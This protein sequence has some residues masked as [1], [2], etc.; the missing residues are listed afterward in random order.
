MKA[1]LEKR[2]IFWLYF[3]IYFL[4]SGLFI[5]AFLSQTKVHAQNETV[6]A[7]LPEITNL[8]FNGDRSAQVQVVISNV[9]LLNAFDITLI[10]DSTVTAVTSWSH[11]GFLS[12]L[13]CPREINDPGFFRLACTQLGIPGVSGSGSLINLT[14]TGTTTGST[15][16]TIDEGS[17]KLPDSNNQPIVASIQNGTITVGYA[18]STVG[19]NFFLQGQSDRAGIP[20]SLGSGV[21]Y[22][23]G[24][25]DALSAPILGQNLVLPSVV[26]NDT[27]TLITAQPRYLNPDASLGLTLTVPSGTDVALPP[28]RLLAGDVVAD[29]VIDTEDLDA[30]RDAFG[31]MG[32]G[33]S[34]DVNFDGVVDLR[35]LA[36][37]GGNFG[38]TP[39]A[40]YGGWLP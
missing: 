35:D 1:F 27:Y 7:V 34:A 11:G 5:Y 31:S 32:E 23:Q 16:V 8:Y 40:A 6:L 2:L 10:Y 38:L 14:F 19:G 30:I 21:T 20:V 36:L 37:A 22:S 28:L 3:L 15:P 33:I 39:A 25:F 29:N 18:T 26:N 17:L 13:S 12:N 9:E 4:L 24:P